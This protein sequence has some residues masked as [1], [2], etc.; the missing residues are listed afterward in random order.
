M[1]RKFF[2]AVGVALGVSAPV[3]AQSLTVVR[4]LPGYTCMSL[5]LTER[6]LLEGSVPVPVRAGPSSNSPQLGFAAAT[7]AV[8]EPA[9]PVN[10]FLE[11]LFPDGRAVWIA[12]SMLRPWKSANDP[13]AQCI[14]SLMSN[15]KPGFDFTN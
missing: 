4:H 7:V 8:R 14:P 9:K 6:Q 15:G 10:G 2:L 12:A 13:N 3:F 5:N 1:H 11:M